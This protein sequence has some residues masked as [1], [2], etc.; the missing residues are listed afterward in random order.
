M[1]NDYRLTRLAERDLEE[2]ADSIGRQNP[3]AAVR[4]LERLLETFSLLA[5]NP[6]LGE[7]RPDLPMNPR[8]FCVGNYLVLYRP[9]T[10]GIEV[11]RVIHAARDI[12]SL[13]RR[14]ENT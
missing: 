3:S 4:Q 10:N 6:L 1:V 2:I 7:L 8:A 12:V 11:A 9:I 13:L 14:Q 5:R